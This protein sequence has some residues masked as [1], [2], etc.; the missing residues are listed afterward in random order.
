MIKHP[1]F[2]FSWPLLAVLGTLILPHL[3]MALDCQ[4][5]AMLSLQKIGQSLNAYYSVFFYF[6]AGPVYSLFAFPALIW[7]FVC[8]FKNPCK[9]TLLWTMFTTWVL[10]GFPGGMLVSLLSYQA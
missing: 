4:D 5:L 8:W 10:C 9:N 7:S 1:L 6:H 2:V 3:Y